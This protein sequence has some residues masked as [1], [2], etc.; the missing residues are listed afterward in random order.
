MSTTRSHRRKNSHLFS[1]RKNSDSTDMSI[2]LNSFS[3]PNPNDIESQ[4]RPEEPNPVPQWS[5]RNRKVPKFTFMA[6][7]ISLMLSFFLLIPMYKTTSVAKNDP[8]PHKDDQTSSKK[9]FT[10]KEVLNGDFLN[11]EKAFHFINP[12]SSILHHDEDPG[13]FLTTETDSNDQTRFVARQLYDPGFSENLG[14]NHFSY[15]GSDHV[16][17]KVQVNYRLDRMIMGT[18]LEPEFRHSSKGYYWL[19]DLEQGTM[20]PIKPESSMDLTL[21]SYVHFSPG[22]N[23]IYFVWENNL[24]IQNVYSGESAS[25][26]TF[27][28]SEDVF[29]GKPDWVY[30]EEIMATGQAVWWSPDDTKMIFARFD[31]TEVE[32]YYLSKYTTNSEYPPMSSIKYPKPGTSN[33]KA[34]LYLFNLNEG[35]LYQLSDLA[36]DDE[37]PVI[38]DTILYNGVWLNS[39]SFIFK[40]TDRTSRRMAI[41][42]YNAKQSSLKTVRSIDSASFDGWFE[43]S[44]NILSIPPNE[45][46]G[47]EGYGYVDIQADADGFNH[48]FYFKSIED[49]QGT[50]LTRGDWEI[51]DTGIVGFEYDTNTVYFTANEI[52]RMSQHLYSVSIDPAEEAHLKILQNADAK[53]FYHFKLSSSGRYALMKMLGPEVPYTA[54]GL[55]PDL[56]DFRKV[57]QKRV[58]EITDNAKLNESLENLALPIKSHKTM[59]TEDGLILDYIEI[60]PAHMDPKKKYPLLVNVYGGPGS[61][62]Y[63]EK[64][65]VFFEEAVSSGLDA[66]VLQIEP[67]G[68]GGKGWKF[69]STVKDKIGYW[70]PRDI[71]MVTRN[72]IQH[73]EANIDKNKTAIWG[74]SY[75]GYT[76][77]KSVEYDQGETFKYMMAVAP[78]TNWT[79]YD[80]F[81]TERYMN[82]PSDNVKGYSDIA[83]VQDL[84]AFSKLDRFLIMHGSADDNVHIQNTYQFIDGLDLQGVTNYDMHIFPDSDHSIRHHNAQRIVFERLYSWLSD[85]FSGHF[86]TNKVS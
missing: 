56:L 14:P 52:D 1:Q 27:D 50:Q 55:L 43:K 32:S 34:K 47:R 82:E 39:D 36:I 18:N 86:H 23:F 64:F 33:P 24:F 15:E 61:Q 4:P 29:N 70:E 77:L 40:I 30:E 85:A 12:S 53:D 57:D 35:V 58:F 11:S 73:N 51:T 65:N 68:T 8:V 7:A 28:G 31:D 60:K 75:G 37:E 6:I 46:S 74:W 45:V 2:E 48:L 42:V 25:Q 16:V 84:D 41:K 79:Y 38:T 62:T 20:K 69:R 67:R 9:A 71:T 17:Q 26:I 10:I 63:T 81:Y 72:F 21:I 13:L 80:S 54:A 5:F 3:Y 59:S 49:A 22:Y 44:K 83:P 76:S 78:V 66:I 19:K